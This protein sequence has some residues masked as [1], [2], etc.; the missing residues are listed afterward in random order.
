MQLALQGLGKRLPNDLQVLQAA[1]YGPG[2]NDATEEV[3]RTLMKGRRRVVA[4]SPMSKCSRSSP[5]SSGLG[6]ICFDRTLALSD[7]SSPLTVAGMDVA[8]AGLKWTGWS[9]AAGW[10]LRN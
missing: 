1:W 9:F 5:P 8:D 10:K 3:K 7:K 4:A 2:V 6:N